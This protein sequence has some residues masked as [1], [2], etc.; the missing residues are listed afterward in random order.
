MKQRQ[1]A[2]WQTNNAEQPSLEKGRA[3]VSNKPEVESGFL[4]DEVRKLW[5]D[6]EDGTESRPEKM[7]PLKG[8]LNDAASATEEQRESGASIQRM[9]VMLREIL[10]AFIEESL[11]ATKT[12]KIVEKKDRWTRKLPPRCRFDREKVLPFAAGA[13]LCYMKVE[14]KLARFHRQ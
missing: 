13:Y 10:Q 1:T 6:V 12:M 9:T 3:C 14:G 8:L 5:A 11:T 4:L 2:H 7:K